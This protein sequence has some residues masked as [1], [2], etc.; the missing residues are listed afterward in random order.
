MEKIPCE[1]KEEPVTYE[2]AIKPFECQIKALALKIVKDLD[3][4]ELNEWAKLETLKIVKTKVEDS[5]GTVVDPGTI[6]VVKEDQR[7]DKLYWEVYNN[8]RVAEEVSDIINSWGY[9]FRN[10]TEEQI[11]QIVSASEHFW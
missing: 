10:Y 8:E 9:K 4:A 7:L 1:T 11:W 6:D 3:A 5:I 2:A